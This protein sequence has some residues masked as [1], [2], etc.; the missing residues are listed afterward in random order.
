MKKIDTYKNEFSKKGYVVIKNFLKKKEVE[1][2]NKYLFITYSKKLN[3]KI[4]KKYS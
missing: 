4:D 1:E 2:F 3:R